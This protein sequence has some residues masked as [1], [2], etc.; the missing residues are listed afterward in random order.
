MPSRKILQYERNYIFIWIKHV[1]I[2]LIFLLFNYQ[3][4]FSAP[5]PSEIP[6]SKTHL[7]RTS[8]SPAQHENISSSKKPNFL[9]DP[10]E[11]KNSMNSNNAKN[12]GSENNLNDKTLDSI[13]KNLGDMDD[14]DAGLFGPSV[15]KK[16][17]PKHNPVTNTETGNIYIYI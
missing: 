15:S 11:I 13:L 3:I 1:F 14:M 12:I 8:F 9:K 5:A 6:S 10:A 17:I 16:T 4:H 2:H 7:P